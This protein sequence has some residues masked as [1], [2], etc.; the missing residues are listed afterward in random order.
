MTAFRQ[1]INDISVSTRNWRVWWLLS[2]NDIRAK[3][4]RTVLGPWW[5]VLGTGIS[6]GGMGVVWGTLFGIDIQEFFPYLVAGYVTWQ[7]LN[8]IL[9]ES[10]EAFTNGHAASIQM[11]IPT[12]KFTH[13]LRVVSR[14][15]IF[16]WHALAIFVVA[17]IVG[18]IVPSAF[19]PLALVGLALIAANGLWVGMLFGVL[20]ARYRDIGPLVNAVMSV[21][22]FVTPIVWKAEQLGSRGYLASFNPFTHFIA[23]VREPLLGHSPSVVSWLV[24]GAITVA[25]YAFA[26]WLFAR[27][28]TRITFWL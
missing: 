16:F 5:I 6:L 28:R 27:V 18:R 21:L 23:L 4:R 22:F 7:L 8:M 15:I 3:Y 24:V 25:G 10:C 14:N 20:G 1:A 11:N 2:W 12:E 17:A 9:V 26:L 19:M 13:V